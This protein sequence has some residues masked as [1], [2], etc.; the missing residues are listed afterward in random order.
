MSLILQLPPDLENYLRSQTPNFEAEAKE[1]ML[2]EWYRQEKLT[3][4][5]L[6]QAL[7]LDRFETEAVL[8]K[9][10]VTEDFPSDQEYDAALAQLAVP[11]AH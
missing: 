4:R 10:H 7:S 9:H 1:A 6:G 5:Q 3:H 2:I 11:K 8:K